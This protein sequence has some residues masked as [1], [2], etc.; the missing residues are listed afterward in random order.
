MRRRRV[1]R[2]LLPLLLVSLA[3]AQF[4]FSQVSIFGRSERSVVLGGVEYARVD[5][6]GNA[7]SVTRSGEVARV[8]GFGRVLLLPIDRVPERASAATNTVQLGVERVQAR[9][10]TLLNDNLYLPLDTLARGLGAQYERGRFSLPSARLTGVSSRA[11]READRV[12][13]DLNRDVRFRT[14]VTARGLEVV[15]PDTTGDTQTYSTRGKFIPT[16]QVRRDGS[17]LVLTVPLS[18]DA[19]FR[20]YRSVRGETVRLVL[21]VGPGIPVTVAPL[22]DRVRQPLIVIDPSLGRG[23]D[24]VGDA[25]LELAREAGELLTAAGWRVRLTRTG[26][27]APD[28]A[29]RAQLARSSDV[30]VTLSVGRVPGSEAKGLTVYEGRGSTGLVLT[31]ALRSSDARGE[32]AQLVVD[33]AGATRRLAQLLMGELKA[34]DVPT[35]SAAAS[36]LYLLREAPRSALLVELGWA[37]NEQDAFRLTDDRSRTQ[38]AAALARSVATFLAARAK[39]TGGR[40]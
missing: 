37:Q 20:T 16:L 2:L 30:F 13:L 24:R 31:D 29:E 40:S 8:E 10:A 1:G 35:R 22:R 7:L 11:G 36:H 14:R 32:L 9:T 4:E 26:P 19:G 28:L 12:V 38:L 39:G 25:A 3:G 23:T 6:L 18:A 33:D 5:A 34:L 17:D 27:D 21:D 15:L